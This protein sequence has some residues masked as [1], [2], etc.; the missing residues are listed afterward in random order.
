MTNDS[1]NKMQRQ[2]S[3]T[4]IILP[5]LIGLAVVA[6][7]IIRDFKPGM[8]SDVSFNTG[9]GTMLLLACVMMFFRDFGYVLR[10]RYLSDKKLSWKQSIN[11]IILWEFSSAVTPSAVGGTSVATYFLW[12]EGFS[13]GKSASIVMATSFLDELYFTLMFPILFLIFSHTGLFPLDENG[14]LNSSFLVFAGVGYGIKLLW[15]LVMATALFVKPVAMKNIL[16]TLFKL[17]ILRKWKE[18]AAHAGE[19]I[20]AASHELRHKTIGFW[21]RSFLATLFSWTSRY[22]VLNFLILA[23]AFG[24]PYFDAHTLFSV[25][26]HFL[27]FARQLVMWIMMLVMPT[28]GGSGFVEAVFTSYMAD[29]I[30][31]VGFVS[32]MALLWRFVTYYPYLIL[33]AIVAPRW[34]AKSRTKIGN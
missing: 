23:L 15:T 26:E 34:F 11:I 14:N 20:V 7:F 33:G 6:F 2:M 30:P 32:A 12:K 8:F 17:R 4:R 27:I 24:L 22:W 13:A 1:H 3:P 28:P 16:N 18:A 21:I 10:I 31:I 9:V 25:G 5:M 29:F 19:D